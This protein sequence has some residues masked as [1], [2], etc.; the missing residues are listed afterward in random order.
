M[1]LGVM[2]LVVT[3]LILMIMNITLN[4]GLGQHV[5]VLAPNRDMPHTISGVSLTK[6]DVSISPVCT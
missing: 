4:R 3:D 6:A 5:L 2:I 1:V